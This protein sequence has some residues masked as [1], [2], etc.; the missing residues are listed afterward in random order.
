MGD[1]VIRRKI[2]GGMRGFLKI[3]GPESLLEFR[4]R[5]DAK[6]H[7]S[8][9]M[10]AEG[11]RMPKMCSG[12]FTNRPPSLFHFHQ[13]T[14]FPDRRGTD[15]F[16]AFEIFHLG[17]GAAFDDGFGGFGSD[18]GERLQPGDGGGVE[19]ERP[20]VDRPED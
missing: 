20:R 12:V 18:P 19:I 2:F 17:I 13:F 3:R 16:D 8:D 9:Q 5:M 10:K 11:N 15:S 6:F 1:G 7:E 14:Q 4:P